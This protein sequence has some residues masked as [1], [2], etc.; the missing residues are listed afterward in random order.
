MDSTWGDGQTTWETKYQQDFKIYP[1]IMSVAALVYLII[2]LSWQCNPHQSQGM[3]Y[4]SQLLFPH[5]SDLCCVCRRHQSNQI[6][7]HLSSGKCIPFPS[8]TLWKPHG[9]LIMNVCPG[10][11]PDFCIC[12]AKGAQFHHGF[13]ML[14]LWPGVVLIICSWS[15]TNEPVCL[16]GVFGWPK[17]PWLWFYLDLSSINCAHSSVLKLYQT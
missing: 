15:V 1:G 11:D 16:P 14:Q 10:L 7:H 4:A 17:Y 2:A 5:G 13:V 6:P 9:K 12:E 8:I 3:A